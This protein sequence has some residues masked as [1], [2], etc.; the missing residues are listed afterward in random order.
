MP[1]ASHRL[2]STPEHSVEVAGEFMGRRRPLEQIQAVEAA[3]ET[4]IYLRDVSLVGQEKVGR[5]AAMITEFKH[6]L[7][8]LIDWRLAAI[9]S[10]V[11]DDV[12]SP[13]AFLPNE[14]RGPVLAFDDNYI[15]LEQRRL[16]GAYKVLESA[17]FDWKT[18]SGSSAITTIDR[19]V[20]C[21]MIPQTNEFPRFSRRRFNHAD[22]DGIEA[23]RKSLEE[24]GE[25]FVETG[26]VHHYF[27]TYP[28]VC[29]AS[30]ELAEV[31]PIRSDRDARVFDGGLVAVAGG[32]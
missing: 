17:G 15:S 13:D 20:V 6:S 9:G 24:V 29:A 31:V 3:E 7:H 28:S 32:A 10:I 5:D 16:A 18:G 11:L 2:N 12:N 25:E 8:G 4:E 22:V 26:D 19:I 14:E 27:V 21:K 30:L 23:Y 1:Y